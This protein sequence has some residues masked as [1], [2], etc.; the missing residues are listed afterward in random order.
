VVSSPR[1]LIAELPE[2]GLIDRHQ[3]AAMRRMLTVL[4]AMLPA[5]YRIITPFPASRD[6][7]WNAAHGT[8]R[9]MNDSFPRAP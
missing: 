8:S 4:D 3:I 1:T 9:P 2:L 5:P 6:Q 7:N